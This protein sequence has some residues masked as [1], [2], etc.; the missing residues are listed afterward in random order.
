MA[1]NYVARAETADYTPTADVAAG[2]IVVIGALVW[3]ANSF[4]AANTT[5]TLVLTGTWDLPQTS[6]SAIAGGVQMYW[7]ATNGVATI[8]SASGA[9]KACGFTVPDGAAASTTTVRVIKSA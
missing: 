8:S 4:I 3:M 1:S 7:D 5:G 9:N 6:G 2:T